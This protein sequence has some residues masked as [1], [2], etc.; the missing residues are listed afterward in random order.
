MK[1]GD[2]LINVCSVSSVML[3]GIAFYNIMTPISHSEKLQQRRKTALEKY[4]DQ[5]EI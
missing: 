5:M 3:V 4:K 1:W 2:I